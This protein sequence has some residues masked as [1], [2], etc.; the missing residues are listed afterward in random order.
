MQNQ[1]ESQFLVTMSTAKPVREKVAAHRQRLR[2]AG[3]IYV[4]TDLPADL[5]DCLDK[6]KAERGLASRAQVFELALKAFVENEMR[7]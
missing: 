7:A 4:N 2:E 1:S 5:V 6:I 3:R